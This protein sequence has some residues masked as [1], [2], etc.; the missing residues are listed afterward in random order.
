MRLATLEKLEEDYF[1]KDIIKEFDEEGLPVDGINKNISDDEL[2]SLIDFYVRYP[3]LK[4]YLLIE[5]AWFRK[6]AWNLRLLNPN[7]RNEDIVR[8]WIMSRQQVAHH[9]EYAERYILG[10]EIEP[11]NTKWVN[12]FLKQAARENDIS[13]Y[14]SILQRLKINPQQP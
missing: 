4:H 10:K 5:G 9:R 6:H 2:I 11:E 13:E 3:S 7:I 12:D 14:S 8:D 1:L